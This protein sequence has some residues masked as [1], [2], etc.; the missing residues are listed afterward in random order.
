MKINYYCIIISFSLILSACSNRNDFS[1]LE[2]AYLGQ[3]P[4]GDK[5]EIF[6]PG[7]ISFGFHEHNFTISPDGR[8]IFYVMTDNQAKQ[9]FIIQVLMKDDI[10]QQPEIA[11]FSGTYND[12]SPSFSPDGKRLFFSSFRPINDLDS[13][14][15]YQEIWVVEKG[16]NGWS[17]PKHIKLNEDLEIREVNPSVS[18][19][20]NLYLQA[21]YED[22][23]DIFRSDLVDGKFMHPV[24]L[25]NPIST[26]MNEGGPCISPDE[27]FIIFHSSR[28]G[29]IG[30]SDI[31][32]SYK[33]DDGAWGE[34]IN[35]GEKINSSNSD[36]TPFLS[37]DGKYLFFTSFRTFS[38]EDFIG[39]S[40]EELIKLYN[41]PLNGFSTIYWVNAEIVD[42][43]KN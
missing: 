30:R 7:I 5:A 32:I 1:K 21:N 23:W 24:K 40:Y 2:G 20:G 11:S 12:V 6:A 9:Y 10:W 29:G 25:E 18:A 22:G 33:D 13:A 31:Y 3:E 34:P 38:A 15:L 19:S 4:P 8:E 37:F 27:K 36:T 42:S 17:E 16:D 26:E 35:F 28:E 39:K 14:E 41:H 43:I